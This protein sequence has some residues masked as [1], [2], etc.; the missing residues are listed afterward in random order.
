VVRGHSSITWSS[1]R[2]TLRTSADPAQPVAPAMIT[3]SG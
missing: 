2:T 3:F 1:P